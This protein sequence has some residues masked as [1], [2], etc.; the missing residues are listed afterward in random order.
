MISY[1]FLKVPEDKTGQRLD[2]FLLAQIAVPKTLLY[3]SMR[4]GLVRVNDRRTKPDY[5]VQEADMVKVPE[6]FIEK[7]S[8][9]KTPPPT[10]LSWL[11]Q[12][13]IADHE[14]FMVIAKPAGLAVHG[15]SGHSYGLIE[16]LRF[17]KPRASLEL[18]HRL[19]KETSGLVLIAKKRSAVRALGAL[20]AERQIH[21]SYLAVVQGRLRKKCVVD[22]PLSIT[23]RQGIRCSVVCDKGDKAQTTFIPLTHTEGQTLCL[24][25]PLTGRMHQIRAHAAYLGMPIVGDRLYGQDKEGQLHLH[26]VQL[27]FDYLQK[28]WLFQHPPP[29]TWDQELFKGWDLWKKMNQLQKSARSC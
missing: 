17:L 26:A 20:F 16:L 22:R 28:N 2:N 6:H 9:P 25:W 21:K 27:S 13:I 15:G 3:K 5:R 7:K 12:F 24:V 19:D 1:S 18:V 4:K 10:D 8:L 11:E 29:L 23:R 14:T